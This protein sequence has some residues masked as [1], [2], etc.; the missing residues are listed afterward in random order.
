MSKCRWSGALASTP[1]CS[2]QITS[3]N[4]QTLGIGGSHPRPLPACLRSSAA[5]PRPLLG[6]QPPGTRRHP[7]SLRVTL[8]PVPGVWMRLTTAGGALAD[9]PPSNHH[10]PCTGQNRG[11]PRLLHPHPARLAAH[12]ARPASPAAGTAHVCCPCFL[13]YL[14][15][16]RPSACNAL[17]SPHGRAARVPC[18]V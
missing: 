3:P 11:R 5:P 4:A 18:A 14:G 15:A 10:P 12:V 2:M 9:L 17:L 8:C 6:L 1:F 16:A 13:H 7:V